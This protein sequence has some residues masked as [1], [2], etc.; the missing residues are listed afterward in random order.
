MHFER[1]QHTTETPA[2]S[3]GGNRGHDSLQ[4]GHRLARHGLGGKVK[5]LLTSVRTRCPDPLREAVAGRCYELP[6]AST[7]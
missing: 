3:H 7:S 4:F 6:P 1:A 2:W 5:W